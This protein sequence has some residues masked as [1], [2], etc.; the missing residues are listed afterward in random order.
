MVAAIAPEAPVLFSTITGCPRAFDSGSAMIRAEVSCT[1]PAGKP[2]SRW[3]GLFGQAAIAAAGAFI[4]EDGVLAPFGCWLSA[5]QQAVAK[6][7]AER[8]RESVNVLFMG[9][10]WF[11]VN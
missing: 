9:Y 7:I 2:M 11:V 6:R 5:G 4:R 8:L 1:E 10:F 3:I